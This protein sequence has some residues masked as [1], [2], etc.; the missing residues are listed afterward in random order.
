MKDPFLQNMLL[1]DCFFYLELL[2]HFGDWQFVPALSVNGCISEEDPVIYENDLID[3]LS[4][5]YH[6]LTFTPFLV[7]NR[8]WFDSELNVFI[9]EDDSDPEVDARLYLKVRERRKK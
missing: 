2:R 8:W 5:N 4:E 9:C 1:K 3:E 7:S 6:P